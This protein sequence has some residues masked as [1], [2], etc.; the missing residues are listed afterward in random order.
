M[1]TITKQTSIRGTNKT[2][3]ATGT[4]KA[5]AWLDQVM[6]AVAGTASG[7]DALAV[8]NRK[9]E[10]DDGDL[11]GH[12]MT[13]PPATETA[14]WIYFRTDVP[15]H[16]FL[17]ERSGSPG[18]Y[19]Y[20]WL[21]PFFVGDY[22]SRI[23][24][25]AAVTPATPNVTW[26]ALNQTFNVSGGDWETDTPNAK[27]FHIVILPSDSNS[28]ILSPLIRI[29]DPDA[30]QI[31][32][33]PPS[34]SGN[35]P[36]SVDNVEEALN[37]FHNATLG[38]GG[39][40]MQQPSDWEA[41]SGVTRI[42]NK[43]LLPQMQEF[44]DPSGT[45]QSANDEVEQSFTIDTDLTQYRTR[46]NRPLYIEAHVQIFTQQAGVDGD[47]EFRFEIIDSSD[48]AL[49]PKA[50]STPIEVQ[51]TNSNSVTTTRTIR[52]NLPN[53]FSGGK[54]RTVLVSTG[55]PVIS[56]VDFYYIRISPDLGAQNII[57][58][59]TDLGNN[60]VTENLNTVEDV[61]SQI[62]ELPIQPSDFEDIEWPGGPSGIDDDGAEVRS[63]VIGIHRNIQNVMSRPNRT[64]Y[65][66]ISF[67]SA[68][69]GSPTDGRSVVNFI[70][71]VYTNV[72]STA[73]STTP[74]NNQGATATT[75]N[76][77]V[78]LPSNATSIRIGFTVPTGQADA[79]LVITEYDLDIVERVSA[80][81]VTVD[82]AEF[83]G[84]L[85]TTDDTVQK[86]AQKL[87]DLTVGAGASGSTYGQRTI[88]NNINRAAN[89]IETVDLV[90]EQITLSSR[91]VDEGGERLN[92]P[93]AITVGYTITIPPALSGN[94][95]TL[96][97]RS[98]N[99]SENAGVTYAQQNISGVTSGNTININAILPHSAN[100]P[101]TFY[102][103]L[104]YTSPSP[105]D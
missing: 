34:T 22:Q 49:T 75:R 96:F 40:I 29:G 83:D 16:F 92:N 101:N 14:P 15:K 87:D 2:Q 4:N 9:T 11:I 39:G 41:A 57:V 46:Y 36:R 69:D 67:K 42:L 72:S 23:I 90:S 105:R 60:I 17:K 89:T 59:Q 1:A 54:L 62:D 31:S 13:T 64:F 88:L 38:G 80:N 44:S 91:L 8:L 86:V 70:H 84:N 103:C 27:W 45:M 61:I 7:E 73:I 99:N 52:G 74:Y 53:N 26:N 65:A 93:I 21:G 51:A 77:E 79:R 32:Y 30:E 10:F 18:S 78:A 6:A 3:R 97:I 5:V 104:L 55:T 35:I 94:V 98:V 28:E 100:I 50:I 58:S 56:D 24:Y 81:L 43:P 12:G 20:F 71:N 63:P 25:S 66:K 102:I 48:N 37:E 76:V 82:A 19:T 33:T 47:L 68:F 85:A 95:G